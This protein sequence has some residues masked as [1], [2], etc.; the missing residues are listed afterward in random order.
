[1][2]VSFSSGLKQDFDKVLKI[3][4]DQVRFRYFTS[5]FAGSYFDTSSSLARSGN[6][7]W[8]SG[9]F[10]PIDAGK[11]SQEQA[12]M[13]QGFVKIGDSRLYIQSNVQT[14]G[15]LK[16]GIGS[17]IRE[18]YSINEGGVI[19]WSVNG[20]QVYKKLYVRYLPTGSLSEE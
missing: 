9:V 8:V 20:V 15:L 10:Q 14:S 17:P 1:M 5:A 12:L 18:E 2:S 13:E 11:G 19:P 6:D 3:A 16:I 4:G 7:V